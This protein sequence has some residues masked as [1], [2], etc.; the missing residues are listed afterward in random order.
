M[1]SNSILRLT[2][3]VEVGNMKDGMNVVGLGVEG[4]PEQHPGSESFFMLQT[5]SHFS[6]TSGVF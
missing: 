3:L 4:V 5:N 6:Y 2:L 1:E